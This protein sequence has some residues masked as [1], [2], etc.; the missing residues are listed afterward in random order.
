M[1]RREFIAGLGG[2][3]AWPLAAHSQQAERTRRIGVLMNLRADDPEGRAR[4]A[5]FRQALQ[6]RGWTIGRNLQVDY[7]WGG[8]DLELRRYAAE[9]VAL[10]PDVL[11]AGGG[12]AVRPLQQ[13]TSTVPIVFTNANDPL[14]S[15]FVASLARPG[16]NTTG[17]I[18]IEYAVT[19]KWVWLLKQIA[20]PVTRA[21]VL[22]DPTATIV[23][24][25]FAAMQAAAHSLDVEL[26]AIDI[27]DAN[28]IVRDVAMFAH[29]ANGGLIVTASTLATRN[30]ELILTLASR[31]RLPA[32]YPNR[33]YVSQGGLA[34]YG[35]I[36]L[37]QF[38]AAAD[39]VD[40]ILKGEKP[41]ELAVQAPTKYQMVLNLRT[42]KAL[43]LEVPTDLLALA[44]EVIE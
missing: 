21:A 42:A 39:Y 17:F 1:R 31:H 18:N 3:A 34:S 41:A 27:R 5:T 7:R 32:V 12:L 28:D 40:R 2:A 14:A 38:R 33:L 26:V 11:L 6:D 4:D 37:D 8:N 23:K 36:F 20:P 9:L 25:Q 35:P 29:E 19:T 44:D 16:G 22:G 15:G 43:D 30:R 24:A 13:A 10:A